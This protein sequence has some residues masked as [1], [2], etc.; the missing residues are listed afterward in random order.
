M[1]KKG[2]TIIEV[3]AVFLLM[4]GV[5]FLILPV[6][7]DNTKQARF[8]SEWTETYSEMEYIAS[9]IKA[10]DDVQLKKKF[11]KA[12][13]NLVIGELVLNTLKPYLRIKT[14]V[15]LSD[16][17]QRYMNKEKVEEGTKYYFDSFYFTEEKQIV[18]LK[19]LNKNCKKEIV[20]GMLTFDINGITPPNTWGK[21]I[22]GVNILEKGIEPIGKNV[23]S[24]ILKKDCSRNGSGAYCSYFY[25]IGGDFD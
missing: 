10:Q 9:V 8:I 18:G 21:D 11:E 19:W 22:F 23:D 15:A 20:C 4:L 7:L 13:N 12:K 2:F 25:L 6:V 17:H 14:G 1:Q 16:Y 24:E 5:T 3:I